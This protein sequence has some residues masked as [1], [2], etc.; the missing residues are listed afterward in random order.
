MLNSSSLQAR[1]E[2]ATRNHIRAVLNTPPSPPTQDTKERN[3][4]FPRCTNTQTYAAESM[5]KNYFKL[6]G[7]NNTEGSSSDEANG[8]QQERQRGL[9]MTP[10]K[11]AFFP[12]P[13]FQSTPE[14]VTRKR[15]PSVRLV[16]GPFLNGCVVNAMATV[17]GG[18]YEATLKAALNH[19]YKPGVGF[20]YY[21]DA[22]KALADL[23][24]HGVYHKRQPQSWSDFPQKALIGVKSKGGG[25]AVLLLGDKIYDSKKPSAVPREHYSLM[26]TSSYIDLS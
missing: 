22:Q 15:E 18:D 16:R 14:V 23:G 10:F 25:H 24:I 2:A 7:T 26:S 6:T 3:T 4:I 9:Q 12:A 11:S 5:R 19:G 21:K 13:R 1:K 17:N 8:S 20:F